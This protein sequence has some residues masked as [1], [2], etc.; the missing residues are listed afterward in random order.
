MVMP[1]TII[2]AQEG[3]HR[4]LLAMIKSLAKRFLS[5]A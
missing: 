2:Q 3:T 4:F 5:E 1:P